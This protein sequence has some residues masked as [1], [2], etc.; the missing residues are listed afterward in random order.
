MKRILL[1]L[2]TSIAILYV[3]AIVLM[4]LYVEL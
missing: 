2:A 4:M 3:P 1:F